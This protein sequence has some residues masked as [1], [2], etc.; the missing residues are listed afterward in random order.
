LALLLAAELDGHPVEFHTW[1]AQ[2]A[3]KIPLLD[4]LKRHRAIEGDTHCA[5]TFWGLMSAPGKPAALALTNCERV[6]KALR[7]HYP[8]HPKDPLKLS[9]LARQ[10]KLDGNDALL[11]ARFL[12]RSPAYLSISTHEGDPNLV[13]NEQYVTLKGF[14]E[15]KEMARDENRRARTSVF[16][17]L[18]AEQGLETR[19]TWNLSASESKEVR[20]CWHKALE[21]ISRDPEGAITAG[22]SLL[23]AACKHV[24]EEFGESS[25]KYLDLPALY[26]RAT[27][28]L[29]FDPRPDVG[30][31]LRRVFS[32]CATAV[33]GIAEL[34][35][36]LGDAHGKGRH[37]A[38]PAK[39]HAEFIVLISAAMSGLLLATL[40]AQRTP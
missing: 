15:V 13:P 14:E 33:N 29:K 9:E 5:V 30:E 37:A 31:P 11:S 7:K 20:A 1:R 39:R 21:R 17:A 12:S 36:Q 16:P 38:K 4:E 23:E 3:K 24:I 28:L 10:T 35:N 27:A 40:D 18:L 22:R 8:R 25:D 2:N 19:L 32:G 26:K 6:F 34:R